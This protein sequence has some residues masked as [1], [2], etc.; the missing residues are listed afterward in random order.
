[1]PENGSKVP[2]I[3]TL[4][5]SNSLPPIHLFA[6]AT[7]ILVGTALLTSACS[8]TKDST[9]TNTPKSVIYKSETKEN[10]ELLE[11]AKEL[12]K[13]DKQKEAKQVIEKMLANDPNS[14]N[15]HHCLAYIYFL[16][17][18][19]DKAITEYTRAIEINPQQADSWHAR[20]EAYMEKKSFE[21]AAID[22]SKAL[23]INP[24]YH[25]WYRRSCA[26]LEQGFYEK[27]IADANQSIAL[28]PKYSPPYL[29]KVSAEHKLGLKI[30]AEA[31]LQKVKSLKVTNGYE[32]GLRSDFLWEDSDPEA[33]AKD[34]T[35][36]ID[37]LPKNSGWF[38]RRA[39]CYL[40]LE[41][42]K[43][44]HADFDL[45]NKYEPNNDWYKD[46]NDTVDDLE[47]DLGHR[48]KTPAQQWAIACSSQLSATN[49]FGLHS[50]SGQAL[51]E[52]NKL[53]AAESMEEGWRITSRADLLTQLHYL[54][55]EGG[56][57]SLWQSYLRIKRG[58][59][60]PEKVDH[61]A[62]DVLR[63]DFKERMAVVDQYGD[64]LGD[65]GLGAWDLCRYIYLV[66]RGYLL[67]LVSEKEAYR[68]MLP[69]AIKIQ[70]KYSS[71]EQMNEEYLIGRKFW[72]YKEWKEG[73]DKSN[74]ITKLLLTQKTSPWVTL[75]WK[76]K[77][78]E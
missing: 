55:S 22:Y 2:Q 75:P 71:W 59:L 7:A 45:A 58:E 18:E 70:Q 48:A 26:Y 46:W 9:D 24:A 67:G 20:G 44:A 4:D 73:I 6:V 49:G 32:L 12:L 36:I 43:E 63:G 34:Y 3:G 13:T 61:V 53:A 65:R 56:H 31:D 74:R 15:A 42:P 47:Y 41:K 23:L 27:A 5:R 10:L 21:Q 19:Q 76:T 38:Y 77:L 64:A 16:A 28:N 62:R 35:A 54:N 39:R 33:A 29:I 17:N 66:R 68:L 78:H 69:I 1:L 25:T 11:R 60:R 30:E 72:S 51:T 52:E 57:D 37:S 40:A 14:A 8:N 50:L